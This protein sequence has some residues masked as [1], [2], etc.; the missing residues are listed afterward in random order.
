MTLTP[1]E[2][3]GTKMGDNHSREGK[4]ALFKVAKV[5]RSPK[6]VLHLMFLGKIGFLEPNPNTYMWKGA[7]PFHSLTSTLGRKMLI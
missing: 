3:E 5:L 4:V 6:R 7:K 1:I 2:I